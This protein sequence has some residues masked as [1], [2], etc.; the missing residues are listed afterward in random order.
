[1]NEV[2]IRKDLAYKTEGGEKLLADLYT[3]PRVEAEQRPPLVILIHG[4]I[5]S[6]VQIK[7]KDWGSFI[8][9]GQVIA[10]SGMA[11][12]TFNHRVRWSNG[13]DAESLAL[14]ASDLRSLIEFLRAGQNSLG[15]DA[16]R[17]CLFS[18]SAG[19]PLLAKFLA[20]GPAY[21]RCYVAFYSF[22]GQ[23][24]QSM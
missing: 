18:F 15:I 16:D 8:S 10:A 21:V 5:P 22:L 12:A 9:W 24:L 23:P 6:E 1:M 11:A 3:P 20:D 7:P 13:F 14:G 17:L 2:G 4:A 19:G